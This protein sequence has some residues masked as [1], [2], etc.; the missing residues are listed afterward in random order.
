MAHYIHIIFWTNSIHRLFSFV[1][2]EI[3]SSKLSALFCSFYL[4]L[5]R[6]QQ[7]RGQQWLWEE[8]SKRRNL[9]LPRFLIWIQ[10]SMFNDKWIIVTKSIIFDVESTTIRHECECEYERGKERWH[11]ILKTYKYTNQWHAWMNFVMDWILEERK[12]WKIYRKLLQIVIYYP[13]HD[14][15]FLFKAIQ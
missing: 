4:D 3:L 2:F 1:A 5:S 13:W 7:T 15:Y 8:R 12:R 11:H 14:A 9:S 6:L 10:R